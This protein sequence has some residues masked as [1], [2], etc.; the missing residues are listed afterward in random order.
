[1][2]RPT[3][4]GPLVRIPR[5]TRAVIEAFY[6]ALQLRTKGAFWHGYYGRDYRFLL[7]TGQL[8]EVL[9]SRS[10][11]STRPLS[12]DLRAL[13][14]PCGIR[15]FKGRNSITVKCLATD[16]GNAVTDM[17]VVIADGRVIEKK[18]GAHS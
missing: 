7:T 9:I 8:A 6:V 12:D 14:S 13:S 4:H 2:H 15:V 17:V 1:M 3:R 18:T 11:A 10:R 16:P 5:D